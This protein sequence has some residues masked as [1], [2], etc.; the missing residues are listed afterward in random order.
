MVRVE[1]KGLSK[2]K[3]KGRT[4]WYAWR[5]GPR[6]SGEP[7]TPQFMASYNR[8]LEEHRTPDKNRFFFVITSY[9]KNGFSTL[10]PSTRDQWGKWL[11]RIADHFGGLQVKQFDRPEKIRSVIL[12]WRNRWVE[13]PR[14]ADY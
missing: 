3:A 4:Y 1:I 13:T 10:A 12:R 8:A 6:L 5:G 11:D 2:V 7:G 9:K 14:T